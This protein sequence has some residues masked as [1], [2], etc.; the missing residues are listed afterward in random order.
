MMDALLS[1]WVYSIL[2]PALHTQARMI[3]SYTF[4]TYINLKPEKIMNFTKTTMTDLTTVYKYKVYNITRTTS[5]QHFFIYSRVA[6]C[7]KIHAHSNLWK[8]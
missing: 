4:F 2:M 6:T 5:F 3:I 7:N 8:T 1:T